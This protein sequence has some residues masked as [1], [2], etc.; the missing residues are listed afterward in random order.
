MTAAV[1]VDVEGD[2]VAVVV[3]VVVVAEAVT[4]DLG[5]PMHRHMLKKAPASEHDPAY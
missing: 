4:V 2:I 1:A 5:A 3:I